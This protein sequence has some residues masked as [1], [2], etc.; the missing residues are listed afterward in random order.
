[1]ISLYSLCREIFFMDKIFFFYSPGYH[2]AADERSLFDITAWILTWIDNFIIEHRGWD[3]H[4]LK[5]G[6]NLQCKLLNLW[7]EIEFTL[8]SFIGE[9]RRGFGT[10]LVGSSFIEKPSGMSKTLDKMGSSLSTY[11]Y[12]IAEFSTGSDLWDSMCEWKSETTVKGTPNR[13]STT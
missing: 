1:M 2:S 11:E 9:F 12:E 10:Y 4:Q 13:C 5:L 6:N 7:K 8:L 3:Q